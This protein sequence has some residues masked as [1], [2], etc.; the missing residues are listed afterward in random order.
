MSIFEKR[1][2]YGTNEGDIWSGEDSPVGERLKA[3][4]LILIHEVLN[5]DGEVQEVIYNVEASNPDPEIQDLIKRAREGLERYFE[6]K[7]QEN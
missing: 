5:K 7:A 1:G 6:A 3:D 4:G 2:P